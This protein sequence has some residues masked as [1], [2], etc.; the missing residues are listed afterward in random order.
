M[1]DEFKRTMKLMWGHSGKMRMACGCSL[2]L[3]GLFC[4]L[5]FVGEWLFVEG[6]DIR[7]RPEQTL[8]GYDYGI[9]SCM[10]FLFSALYGNAKMV[11][12]NT[13]KWL[14]GSKLGKS[15]MIKGLIVNRLIIF[16]AMFLPCLIS[17]IWLVCQGHG[18]N[19]RVGLFFTVWGA[20]YLISSVTCVSEVAFILIAV[21]YIVS[22]VWDKFWV[23]AAGIQLSVPAAVV[24]FAACLVAGTFIEKKAL[25]ATYKRRECRPQTLLQSEAGKRSVS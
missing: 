17:R 23:F 10:M 20:V 4:V 21:L 2:I 13:G 5:S 19:A 22:T 18:E 24:I 11:M 6:L 9:V 14:L 25:E 16:G 7:H 15:V 1:K 3:I 12:G 8:N